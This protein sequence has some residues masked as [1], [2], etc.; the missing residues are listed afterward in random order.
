VGCGGLRGAQLFNGVM[1]GD[2]GLAVVDV[3]ETGGAG[4]GDGVFGRGTVLA[5]SAGRHTDSDAECDGTQVKSFGRD[6]HSQPL[7][8]QI[9]LTC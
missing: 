7:G 5:S 2:A 8:G 1:A 9:N 3:A 4:E 6:E